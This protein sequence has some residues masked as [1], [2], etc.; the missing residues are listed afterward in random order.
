LAF[1]WLSVTLLFNQL[2]SG[3][4]VIL[5][6]M[7]KLQYL[8]KANLYGSALG[9]VVTIPLY[10]KWGID[11]I[12]PGII[13]SSLISLFF[14]LF[15][16]SK[17]KIEPVKVNKIR[18]IAESKSMLILGFIIGLSGIFSLVSS[19]LMRIFISN[20]G[21][22]AEVGLYS[23]GFT[24]LGTYIGL[25]F[26]SMNVDYY[27]RL[28]EVA[29]DNHKT[30]KLINQQAQICILILAPILTFFLVFIHW[31]IILFYSEEFLIVNK[32]LQWAV[33]GILFKSIH[34]SILVLFYA[35]G[36]SRLIFWNE[37]ISNVYFL[38]INIGGYYL[39]G[40]DGL[41]IS[42]LINYFLVF[43]QVL[44][45]AKVKYE[46]TIEKD[47]KIIFAVQFI[48]LI[49]TFSIVNFLSLF[50]AY[51][52]GSIF[53]NHFSIVFFIRIT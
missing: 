44:I 26:N 17:V 21:S 36:A 49:A 18:T 38:C 8:A 7:R 24:V 43:L 6:G 50:Y 51:F 20:N 11:A 53:N 2:A 14:S 46:Y 28:S 13:I 47:R 42:Y 45:I 29:K 12:V 41:G 9:L 33:L 40:I 52:F 19:Y 25:V 3:Q 31:F 4:M 23:A 37:L 32:M 27:P 22:L 35:K 39:N 5:Q 16:S 10:Y 48:I 30:T 15:F 1:V 34:W